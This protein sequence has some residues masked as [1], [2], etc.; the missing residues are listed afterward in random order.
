MAL[1][2]F[3]QQDKSASYGVTLWDGVR[4]ILVGDSGEVDGFGAESILTA[5]FTMD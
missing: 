3:I 1:F 5:R 4:S 2:G